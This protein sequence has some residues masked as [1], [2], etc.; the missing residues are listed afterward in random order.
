MTRSPDRTAP[1][2]AQ[3]PERP[4]D[5]ADQA[6]PPDAGDVAGAD[7]TATQS[8]WWRHGGVIVA[9]AALARF[10]LH[11][12]A[13]L[14]IAILFS[15]VRRN[16]YARLGGT[17]LIGWWTFTWARNGI[18]PLIGLGVL[19][20]AGAAYSVAAL[21]ERPGWPAMAR[22]AAMA[23]IA[24]C[25]G[26]LNIVPWGTSSPRFGEDEALRRAVAASGRRVQA[27][28]AQVEPGRERLTQRPV[29]WVLLFEPNETTATTLDGE[30]CFRRAAVHAVDALTGAV[31]RSDLLGRLLLA[32]H[33]STVAEAREK[34][35][36][37]LPLPRGTARDVV[38]IPAG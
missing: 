32:D 37:C 5:P 35:G 18:P 16:P 4:A 7:P 14:A 21:S 29:Y 12:C 23:A 26:V 10:R 1:P 22:N 30:P 20:A 2:P 9:L 8:P 31:D 27:T 34:D 33:R 11:F 38:P 28:H 36:F 17:L 15:D 25:L 19:L 24:V 3:R 6:H 13:L